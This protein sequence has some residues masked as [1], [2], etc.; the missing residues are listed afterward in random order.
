MWNAWTVPGQYEGFY[1]YSLHTDI[2]ENKEIGQDPR[3]GSKGE[4]MRLS[5]YEGEGFSLILLI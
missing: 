3:E 1:T 2:E 4:R 5:D